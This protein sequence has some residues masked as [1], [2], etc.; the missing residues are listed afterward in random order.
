MSA[1]AI[2]FLSILTA[3]AVMIMFWK[4]GFTKILRRELL[5]DV[6]ATGGLAAL[7]AG[8]FAGITI[9]ILAGLLVSIELRAVR[10]FGGYRIVKH[11]RRF[12]FA[13]T[14]VIH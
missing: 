12:W 2:M 10:H 11:P 4:I 8:S 7:M 3:Q 9:A 14:E 5:A 13:R 1:T 6:L